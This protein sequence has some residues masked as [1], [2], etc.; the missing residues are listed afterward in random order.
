MEQIIK[1]DKI[2]SE[3]T[4]KFHIIDEIQII[5]G[6]ELYFTLDSKCF[7]KQQVK[8]CINSFT[9]FIEKQL[10][11]EIVDENELSEFVKTISKKFDSKITLYDI[12][13]FIE[14]G[15]LIKRSLIY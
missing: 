1:G 15:V 13:L 12:D 3:S 7:L 9:D 5:Q 14:T 8:K 4:Q 6:V 2:F 10:N 11:E